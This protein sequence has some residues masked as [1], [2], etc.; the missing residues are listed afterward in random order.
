MV[1]SML[2]DMYVLVETMRTFTYRT[3]AAAAA[4]EIGEGGRGDIHKLT[5]ASVMYAADSV[6]TVL[7]KAMQ[8]HGGSGYIWEAEINRLYRSTK[9]LEI[10]A[11]TTEVR[12]MIIAGELLKDMRAMNDG[13]QTFGLDDDA[14]ATHATALRPTPMR[15]RSRSSPAARAAS[16]ARSP[17]CSRG[18]APMSWSPAAAKAKLDAARRGDDR[19]RPEGVARSRRRPR[20]GA[21]RRAVR[22]RLVRCAAR[23]DLLVNSAG[24][25]FPQA[26]IDFSVKGWNAVINTNLNG[27][28]HMMQAAA[29]RWRDAKRPGAHRQY[30][31]RDDAR[32]LRRRAH[33]RRALWRH[34]PHA[35]R[36]G[37]MGAARHSRQLHRAG[38]DR[39]RRLEGLFAG[40][41]RRLSALQS[42]DARR[43]ARGTSPRPAPISAAPPPAM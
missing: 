18:L 36:R 22:A 26:A 5:A 23:L 15:A 16:D 35:R 21:G 33:D 37:R 34:R 9:L 31:R 40:G 27:T 41:A 12:K 38:R 4:I 19:A 8:I 42:D 30:C 11:G 7:D 3:L 24:G 17:G 6:H 20:A 29:R 25:Q 14:L 10:G 28:W 32:A 13:G 1:Q 39:D 43:H 2:A